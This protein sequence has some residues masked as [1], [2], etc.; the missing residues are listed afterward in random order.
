MNMNQ[1]K[2]WIQGHAD[3]A[4]DLVRIY[5]GI[6]LFFKAIY[7]MSHRD[8][9]IRLLNDAG[10]LYVAPAMAAHYVIPAHLLGGL[11]LTIGLLTR[12]AA[13][14]QIPILLGAIFYVHLPNMMRVEP[15]Q[16]LEFATLVLFLLVLVFMYGGG[17]WSVDYLL[18][19]KEKTALHPQPAT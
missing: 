17:R 4:I 13:L 3:L 5:L 11:L 15:R 16:E 19:R 1:C 10:N 14:V 2:Q 9:L 8:D 6:G 12:I 7:F 18:S